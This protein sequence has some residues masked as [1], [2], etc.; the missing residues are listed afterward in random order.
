ISSFF[1]FDVNAEF[2]VD[3]IPALIPTLGSLSHMYARVR[4]I[5][6]LRILLERMWNDWSLQ[7][8]NYEIKIMH[9]HAETTRL[10]TV[11]YSCKKNIKFRFIYEGAR[12]AFLSIRSTLYFCV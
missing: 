8:T 3:V 9:E 2:I 11:C 6:K 5:D 4:N 1:T 7:K 10:V 12:C